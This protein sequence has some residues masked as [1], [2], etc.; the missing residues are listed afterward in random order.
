MAW[1]L[2]KQRG[3]FTFQRHCEFSIFGLKTYTCGIHLGDILWLQWF[4]YL[5]GRTCFTRY[6]W[7]GEKHMRRY[8]GWLW[9]WKYN[10]VYIFIQTVDS[11]QRN[12]SIF[13]L[14]MD[15][16]MWHL[17]SETVVS[18]SDNFIDLPVRCV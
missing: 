18:M 4:W 1:Y 3:N 8:S 7:F 17:C 10:F 6:P 9:R 13:E 5:Y 12:V 16:I 14:G 15:C 11:A 2:V